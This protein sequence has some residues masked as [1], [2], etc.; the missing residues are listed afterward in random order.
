MLYNH[1]PFRP[2]NVWMP[3]YLMKRNEIVTYHY[4]YEH[5]LMITLFVRTYKSLLA[6][7]SSQPAAIISTGIPDAK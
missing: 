3:Q 1:Q 5:I 2:E 6:A 7:R 4:Y